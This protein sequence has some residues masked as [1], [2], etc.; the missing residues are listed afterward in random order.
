M[1]V[2][3]LILSCISLT[4]LVKNEKIE[5]NTKSVSIIIFAILTV[6]AM[7]L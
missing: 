3:V 2:L 4:Y 1:S 6:G 7:F 5:S